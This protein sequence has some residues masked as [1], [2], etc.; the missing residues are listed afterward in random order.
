MLRFVS[1]CASLDEL[2]ETFASLI[3]ETSLFICTK[4]VFDVGLR[5]RF[6][7][8]LRN[9]TPVLRG[10]AEVQES[11]ARLAG[12]SSP[13]GI[14][15]KLL[16][17]TPDSLQLRERLLERKREK[18]VTQVDP[19]PLPPVPMPPVRTIAPRRGRSGRF[20]TTPGAGPV[21]PPGERISGIMAAIAAD[22]SSAP[23][24]AA[25]SEVVRTDSVPNKVEPVQVKIE[26]VPVK[27]EVS[28]P[29]IPVK[30]VPDPHAVS[31]RTLNALARAL[32][33]AGRAP[34]VQ[35]A[36]AAAA[37]ASAVSL[38]STGP[39]A[40]RARI[41]EPPAAVPEPTASETTIPEATAERITSVAGALDADEENELDA[42]ARTRPRAPSVA[43]SEAPHE[44]RAPSSDII[45]PANPLSEIS[46]RSL[47][48]MIEVVIYEDDLPPRD[49]SFDNLLTPRPMTIPPPLAA[50]PEGAG[51][52]ASAAAI[53]LGLLDGR[54]RTATASPHPVG[55]PRGGGARRFFIALLAIA[56]GFG[57]GYLVF[58]T[59][60]L[61]RGG[62]DAEPAPAAAQTAATTSDP[63]PPPATGDEQPAPA[64]TADPPATCTAAID[65]A[66]PT[67]RVLLDDKE[68][69]VG[70]LEDIAVPCDKQFNLKVEHA[71]YRT[72][73]RRFTAATGVPLR[74]DAALTRQEPAVVKKS[75]LRIATEPA[76]AIVTV[77][78]KVVGRGPASVTVGTGD[79]VF[80]TATL[81]GHKGWS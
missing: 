36:A 25:P 42:D 73:E 44:E 61:R 75:R 4:N 55:E 2:V 78:G 43:I 76:G 11:P 39:A 37:L 52:G 66:P 20:Q 60:L 74:I 62:G 53:D 69:G 35:P 23:A 51:N 54:A 26:S 3:D 10:E 33:P 21:L 65:T 56:L 22:G 8:T 17:L 47:E 19:P 7:V 77:D 46:D 67:A 50:P 32:D 30:P 28:D 49:D 1:R 31:G 27:A 6:A 70:S 80:V 12:P 34:A 29:H 57:S 64:A 40:D 41:P 38:K 58:G 45:L 15:L 81:K 9:G 5:R 18:E 63:A 24:T 48:A 13:I 14:R 72:F 16:K 79:T 59:D 71:G 68:I